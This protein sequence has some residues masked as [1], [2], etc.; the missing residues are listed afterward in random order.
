[1]IEV[2]MLIVL[3]I[4]HFISD[5]VLQ[6]SEMALNKSKSNFWLGYHCL[7]YSVLFM[8]FVS[9]LYGIVNGVLHFGIDY[10]TSRTTSKLWQKQDYHNFFVVIGFDQMLHMICL[11]L[12][13]QYLI[14]V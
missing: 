3:F 10:I 12:T 7:V 9:P 13:Y 5:F 6:S 8:V 14:L 1:M 2:K 4:F 11:V